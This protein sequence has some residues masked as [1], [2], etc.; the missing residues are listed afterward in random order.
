[1]RVAL[2]YNLIRSYMFRTGPLDRFAEYDSQETIAALVAAIEAGGHE[3][4]PLEA[5]ECIAEKLKAA[6]P[7]IVF[8]IAEGLRGESRESHVPAICEMLGLPYTG[9][10]PL[11]L[12]LCL[13]K[14]R[15][16]E[17]LTLYGIPTAP[18]QVFRSPH[19]ALDSRL[20]WP[21]IVKLLH[22]GSS[23]GLSEHSVVDDEAALREQVAYLTQTYGEPCIVEEYIVGREFT[24]GVL[25][26]NGTPRVLPIIEVRFKKARG[27][28]L[29]EPDA[30]VIPLILQ[31]RGTDP[32][33]EHV[34]H[35]AN[36]HAICPADIDDELAQRIQDTA[37]RAFGA[38][39]CRDWCRMEMRQGSDNQL[40]VLELNPI[41][42]IDP[43]YWL[44]RA[45]RVAGLSYAEF[46][47]E[48]LGYALVR[49]GLA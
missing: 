42:G 40:Y 47:N 46:V 3:I 26:G 7:D 44:P 11:T 2:T 48:I 17:I 28:V 45:A 35:A 37:I 6:R 4:T 24:V 38:L 20:R 43:T 23:M 33:V 19:D 29:F 49:T 27:I 22:E 14:A 13:N 21:L 31:E 10:G 30:P 15:T 5:D 12:A 34:L 16:K 18:F 39:G 9:S 25:G 36:H 32:E 41:A 8:N 1:M